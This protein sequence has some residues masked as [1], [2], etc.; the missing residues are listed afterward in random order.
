[1][2]SRFLLRR[3]LSPSYAQSVRDGYTFERLRALGFPTINTGCPTLW[4]LTPSLCHTIPAE[5]SAA[6]LLTFTE[7]NQAPEADKLLFECLAKRYSKIYFWP[8]MYGDY[9]YAR[10]LCG[11]A[12]EI[13]PPSLEALD[14]LLRGES[15]DFVGTRLHAG[16]RALQHR[17]RAIIIAV[18]NRALEMAADFNLPVL[19]RNDIATQLERRIE[20]SWKTE[21]RLGAQAIETWKR[22]FTGITAT[23]AM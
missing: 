8:Q 21:V 2:A 23:P 15:L 7:Y 5:K 14:D 3:I 16:I 11:N 13:V 19:H 1:M 6:V 12:L 4:G 10:K 20:T 22:Q 18:D 17:R 9:A